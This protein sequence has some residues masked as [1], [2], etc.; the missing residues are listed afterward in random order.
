[1]NGKLADYRHITILSGY[2]DI[3]IKAQSPPF[4]GLRQRVNLLA[5]FA[6][7]SL[8]RVDRACV[9]PDSVKLVHNYSPSAS[10][11]VFVVVVSSVEV[12]VVFFLAG[13]GSG[14]SINALTRPAYSGLRK[15]F[16]KSFSQ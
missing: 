4:G 15:K 6:K 11:G 9:S 14:A 5:S 16:G 10:A 8:S 1:L 12:F 13:A 3:P 2:W 7:S